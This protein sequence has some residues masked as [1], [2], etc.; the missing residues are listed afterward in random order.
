MS[1]RAEF[2]KDR[3]LISAAVAHVRRFLCLAMPS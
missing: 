3:L 1:N 2:R